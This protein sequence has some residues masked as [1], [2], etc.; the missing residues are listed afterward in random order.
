VRYVITAPLVA[1]SHCHCE[2][3]RRAHGAAFVSWATLLASTLHVTEGA[4][5]IAR[6]DSSPG[7]HRSFCSTC[8]SPLFMHYDAEPESAWVAF[9]SLVTVPERTPDRHYSFEERAA[10]FPFRDDL[11]KLLAKTT[12][13]V[14]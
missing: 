1:A 6:Y 14:E 2:S 12:E 10:W 8:G 3:C 5:R 13:P 9:A 7:A 4:H 11:P